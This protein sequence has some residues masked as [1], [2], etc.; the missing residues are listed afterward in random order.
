MILTWENQSCRRKTY[1][2]T[3]FSTIYLTVTDLR[4]NLGPQGEMSETKDEK[5]PNDVKRFSSYRA[6]YRVLLVDT[7]EAVYI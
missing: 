1:P 6:V 7:R 3:T 4:S 2:S 5:W